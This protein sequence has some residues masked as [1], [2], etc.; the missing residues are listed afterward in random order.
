VRHFIK[1]CQVAVF[2]LSAKSPL[3]LDLVDSRLD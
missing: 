3:M 1:L 2:Y